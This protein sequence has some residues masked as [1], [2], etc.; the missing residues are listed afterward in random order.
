MKKIVCFLV[1]VVVLV[2]IVGIFVA[3]IFIV[4]GGYVQSDVQG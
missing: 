4:I 1:L 2:F 3:V